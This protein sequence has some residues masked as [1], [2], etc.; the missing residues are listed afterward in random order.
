MSPEKEPLF[1]EDLR[2]LPWTSDTGKPCYLAPGADDG[3]ISA[4]A[5]AAEDRQIGEAAR[6]LRECEAVL[7]QPAAG[8]LALRLALT[9][10]ARALRDVARVAH[11]RGLRLGACGEE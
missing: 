1:Q 4:L 3:M 2:L 10:A 5:D 11:S 9:A 6:V 7:A 8:A